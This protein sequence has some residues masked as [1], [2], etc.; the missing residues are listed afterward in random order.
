MFLCCW[1][2]QKEPKT[3]ETLLNLTEVEDCESQPGE[4]VE[5]MQDCGRLVEQEPAVHQ[6]EGISC[7]RKKKKKQH[8]P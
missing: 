1:W 3:P 4:C 8:F 2:P 5:Q 7:R 6:S